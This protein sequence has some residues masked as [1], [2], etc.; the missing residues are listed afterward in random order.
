[1]SADEISRET[2]SEIDRESLSPAVAA[3]L[4][5]NPK[6]HDAYHAG[7]EHIDIPHPTSV[8]AHELLHQDP[9]DLDAPLPKRAMRLASF[10]VPNETYSET[11]AAVHEHLRD[12]D[13][14]HRS[15]IA[16]SALWTGA[17]IGSYNEDAVSSA[18]V[19]IDRLEERAAR[20]KQ[21]TGR[22]RTFPN[23]SA[24]AQAKI[25]I[26]IKQKIRAWMSVRNESES[27]LVRVLLE[28]GLILLDERTKRYEAHMA[29]E[30]L[31]A[32]AA[33][34]A[35]STDPQE[36]GAL[37]QQVIAAIEPERY[38]DPESPTLE[39]AT[40]MVDPMQGAPFEVRAVVAVA[41]AKPGASFTWY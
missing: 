37:H 19:R 12:A 25:P 17:H 35:L 1:V 38:L 26:E 33:A 15:E 34:A 10:P 30:L 13:I 32:G 6:L 9:F 24:F 8:R 31:K 2:F 5:R 16:A 18:L 7:D 41:P 23:G 39:Q 4:A 3:A 20:Y 27:Q 21:A 29:R 28:M 14:R 22:M 40:Q 36:A 11:V